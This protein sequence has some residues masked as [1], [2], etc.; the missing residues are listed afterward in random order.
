MMNQISNFLVDF[1][2]YTMIEGFIFYFIYF[3]YKNMKFNGFFSFFKDAIRCSVLYSFLFCISSRILPFG[4]YQTVAIIFFIFVT[5]F[6][7]KENYISSTYISF[8]FCFIIIV[9]EFLLIIFLNMF[10]NINILSVSLTNFNRILFFI[11]AKFL[12]VFIVFVWRCFRMKAAI[13]TV[14]RR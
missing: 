6:Y 5:K 1:L 9:F 7:F 8:L 10:F 4:I 14:T 3:T 13:G 2:F 11:F 12:E